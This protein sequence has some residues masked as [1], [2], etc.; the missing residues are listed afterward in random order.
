MVYSSSLLFLS[1][2]FNSSNQQK[3]SHSDVSI[4]QCCLFHPFEKQRQITITIPFTRSTFYFPFDPTQTR[5][6]LQLFSIRFHWTEQRA[7][8]LVFPV[9][10]TPPA[11]HPRL[12]RAPR[13]PLSTL[14]QTKLYGRRE[15]G[16][17]KVRHRKALCSD[18]AGV[19]LLRCHSVTPTPVESDLEDH[20]RPRKTH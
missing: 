15:R 13:A 20:G 5:L 2:L 4:S 1:W 11:S 3:K 14:L 8:C 16:G 7:A 12:G 17:G 10:H 18:I 9:T 19:H 6:G